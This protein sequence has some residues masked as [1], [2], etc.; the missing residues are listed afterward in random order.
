MFRQGCG[1]CGSYSVSHRCSNCKSIHY[2]SRGCQKTHWKKTHR[3]DCAIMV[4][5]KIIND[6]DQTYIM[7]QRNDVMTF[8]I[9][10]TLTNTPETSEIHFRDIRWEGVDVVVF[11]IPPTIALRGLS[12]IQSLCGFELMNG[13]ISIDAQPEKPIVQSMQQYHTWSPDDIHNCDHARDLIVM[14]LMICN[15]LNVYFP[16]ELQFEIIPYII[17]DVHTCKDTRPTIVPLMGPNVFV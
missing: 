4:G 7:M 1:S 9:A 8:V 15:R 16:L 17:A 14:W 12:L 11:R 2:C 3:G 13:V 5:Q 6:P 10:F